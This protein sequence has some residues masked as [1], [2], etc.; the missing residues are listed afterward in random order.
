M[1]IIILPMK[2]EDYL[3]TANTNSTN[4]ITTPALSNNAS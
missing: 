1:R 4:A 3:K 2:S